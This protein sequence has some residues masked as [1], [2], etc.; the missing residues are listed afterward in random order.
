MARNPNNRRTHA[1]CGSS[2]E[3]AATA[4]EEPARI[5]PEYAIIDLYATPY[6][7]MQQA[8]GHV[9]SRSKQ[10]PLT[11]TNITTYRP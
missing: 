7:E 5:R 1:D 9:S 2:S 6:E 8:P 11:P 3:P 10:L 4:A